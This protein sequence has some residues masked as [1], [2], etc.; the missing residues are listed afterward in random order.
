MLNVTR[1][2]VADRWGLPFWQL[3]RDIQAQ[4]F[5][6]AE[7]AKIVGM[8]YKGFT[9]LLRDN[10]DKNPWGSCNVVVNYVR[11]TGEP[12]RD[13]LLRMQREGYSFNRA[14]RE[15]GFSGANTAYGLKYAMKARGIEVKFE[16]VRQPKEARKKV[17][18][19]PN[20]TTGWPSWQQIDVMKQ[21]RKPTE[22]GDT[23]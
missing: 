16:W 13:A 11:D 6:R 22:L 15:I 1:K 14:S 18:R 17:D 9:A 2:R 10:P 23:Q 4:D 20:V 7:A 5:N 8:G 3:I 21:P 12:F 19:G